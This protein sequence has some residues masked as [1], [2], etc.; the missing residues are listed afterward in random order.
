M[1]AHSYGRS[2]FGRRFRIHGDFPAIRDL[3]AS[4]HQVIDQLKALQERSHP[5]VLT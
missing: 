5:I 3:Q 2:E 4:Q 1:A